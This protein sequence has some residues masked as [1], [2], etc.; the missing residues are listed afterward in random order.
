MISI[1]VDLRQTNCSTGSVLIQASTDYSNVVA[2]KQTFELCIA[3][4]NFDTAVFFS[5]FLVLDSL[6]V[7]QYSGTCCFELSRRSPC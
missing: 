6:V 3:V 7:I 4:L 2:L 1:C 5:L